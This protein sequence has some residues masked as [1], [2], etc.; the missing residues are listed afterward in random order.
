MSDFSNNLARF[1]D[2]AGIARKEMADI[3]GV[4]VQTYGA[5]EN[6]K[7]EPSID[8]L[9]KIAD[10]LNVPLD[11]LLGRGGHQDNIAFAE[12]CGL[13]VTESGGQI[14]LELSEEI[15]NRLTNFGK[16][17]AEGKKLTPQLFDYIVER[18][19]GDFMNR[20]KTPAALLVLEHVWLEFELF[21]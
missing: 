2:S 21:V 18:A 12:A 4:T 20:Y 11:S 14:S 19:R 8:K 10:T 17:K 1:R 3:L 6:G 5:Y 16:A 7:R 15:R 13:V 9:I